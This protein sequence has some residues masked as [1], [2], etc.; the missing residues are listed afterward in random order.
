MRRCYASGRTHLVSARLEQ[1]IKQQSENVIGR[2]EPT[3][4]IENSES[5][6][7][8]VCRQARERFLFNHRF[9]QWREMVFRRIGTAAVKQHVARFSYRRDVD[10]VASEYSVE[11]SGTAP[12]QSIA[13]EAALHFLDHV[14][15][16][17][18]FELRKIR[19]ARIDP[20]EVVLD[21]EHRA[22]LFPESCGAV[23]DVFRDIGQCR[24]A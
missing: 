9:F 17:Q 5:V 20:W 1:V 24:T 18:L 11:P 15:A 6:R 12:V 8:A 13:N 14:E 23:L 19:L 22:R 10:T 3:V 2:N 16:N 21:V 4:P 7:I